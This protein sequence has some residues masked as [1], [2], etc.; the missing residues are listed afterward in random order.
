MTDHYA[1]FRPLLER[2]RVVYFVYDSAEQRVVYVSKAF[3]QLTGDPADHINEDLPHLL[4][5]LHPDDQQHVVQLLEQAEPEQVLEGIELRL[6]RPDGGIQWLNVSLCRVPGPDNKPY[7]TGTAEDI[8]PIKE[9]M[10]NLQR[11]GTKKNAVLEILSHD[12][13][14]PLLV[15]QQ[16][17]EHL[18]RETNGQLS[19]QAQKMLLLMQRT[20]RESVNMIHDFVDAEF[21]E[22]ANIELNLER[23]DLVVW[24]KTLVEEY[25][26]SEDLL[27]L[28]FSLEAPPEPVY[29]HIDVDKFHQVINN[30]ISNAVKFTPLGG[31]IMLRIEPQAEQVL[32]GVADT[33]IGIPEPMQPY[34][35]EKFTKA[36]RPGLRG[37]KTTGL[38][39]SVIQTI[40]ELHQATI[41]FVS[42]EGQGSTFT[43][44][45]PALTT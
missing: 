10:Q 25:Q 40:V 19:A 3:E 30:L 34:L 28:E 12:L 6:T 33:G 22:S 7:L 41:S 17:T 15:L 44:A 8:T 36:R 39:M 31:Q 43:I 4:R 5:R 32:L 16:L 11:F 24:V 21:L 14:G 23:T 45:L 35:F 20:C 1:L 9:G 13:A 42:A 27:H 38:G 37:E 18:E 26:R 2:G 29:V